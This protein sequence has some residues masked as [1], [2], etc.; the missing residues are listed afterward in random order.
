MK[1][2]TAIVLLF[3][4]VIFVSCEGPMGP[5]GVPGQDGDY[6]IGTIFEMQGD[7]RPSN[8]Y[9]LF[10]DFPGDFEIY[11]TDVVLVYIL[12]E[13]LDINGQA[14]DLWRL[15]PQTVILN[16]GLLQYNY[17]YTVADV[18][19]FLEGTTD[20]N[21]LLPAETDNQVFRIA[22]L[23]A[24]FIAKKSIDINDFNSLITLPSIELNSL[25]NINIQQFER[26]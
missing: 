23:P 2:L 4:M 1:K 22:V 9:E 8:N 25:E 7:F 20:F 19:M 5:P 13:V 14:T 10:F 15:L 16:D 12:W 26:R 18:R 3:I 17:D 11:D 24:D 6:L 21:N